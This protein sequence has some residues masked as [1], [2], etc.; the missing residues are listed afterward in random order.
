M[1]IEIGKFY[2]TRDGRKARIYAVDAGEPYPVHGGYKITS[3]KWDN[4]SWTILGNVNDQHVG[5][6]L[7][8]VSEW[9][10]LCTGT[11]WLN[12]YPCDAI[13]YRDKDIADRCRGAD[14]LACI[15][16]DWTEGEGL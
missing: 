15:K 4:E 8:L 14:L 9:Q 12:V 2:R 10:E 16:V 1:K 3:G 11:V 7:D 5:R 6:D 13:A